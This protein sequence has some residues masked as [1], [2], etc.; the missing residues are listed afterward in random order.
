MTNPT[1]SKPVTN[2]HW[3]HPR[4]SSD[5][6]PTDP[7][8]HRIEAWQNPKRKPHGTPTEA[9]EKSVNPFTAGRVHNL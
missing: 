5:R 7:L 8:Q 2:S 3:Q 9:L 6:S 1:L 4:N